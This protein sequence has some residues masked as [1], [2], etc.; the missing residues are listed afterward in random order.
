MRILTDVSR[1]LVLLDCVESGNQADAMVADDHNPRRK[2][3]YG[4]LNLPVN[5]DLC[6]GLTL[7]LTIITY[8][9]YTPGDI[10]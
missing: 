3:D 4:N 5:H 8:V 9:N 6:I 1:N 7:R 2:I 10:Q